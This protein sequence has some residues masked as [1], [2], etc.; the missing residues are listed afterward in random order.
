M[1]CK[2]NDLQLPMNP[3]LTQEDILQYIYKETSPEKSKIIAD[4]IN[5][6]RGAKLFYLETMDTI[7]NLD[8]LKCDPADTSIR[9]VMEAISKSNR[10]EETH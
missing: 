1:R 6:D 7:K 8:E 5:K 10:L 9:I 3:K 4:F 2:Y